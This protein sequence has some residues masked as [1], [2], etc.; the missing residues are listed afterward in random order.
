MSVSRRG[1]RRCA[2]ADDR[3]ALVSAARRQHLIVEL[4]PGPLQTLCI[5]FVTLV[6]DQSD[7]ACGARTFACR[8]R[9]SQWITDGAAVRRPRE[10]LGQGITRDEYDVCLIKQRLVLHMV[11]TSPTHRQL[12]VEAAQHFHQA[13]D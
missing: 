1:H 13:Y 3:E 5:E 4:F 12:A 8:Q 7:V 6:V 9:C 10:P 11:E 2:E